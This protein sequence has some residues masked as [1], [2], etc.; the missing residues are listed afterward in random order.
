MSVR[1]REDKKTSHFILLT[2]DKKYSFYTDS[3]REAMQWTAIIEDVANNLIH[4]NIGS[5]AKNI[6]SIQSQSVGFQL[7][8]FNLIFFFNLNCKFNFK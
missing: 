5:T 6:K 3:E 7:K 2:P 1:L 8:N 4:K